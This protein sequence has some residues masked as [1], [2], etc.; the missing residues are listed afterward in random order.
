MGST[1][2]RAQHHKRKI[3]QCFIGRSQVWSRSLS[4]CK[5]EWIQ[6][7]RRWQARIF[8]MDNF[9]PAKTMREC[10]FYTW[11]MGTD[12]HQPAAIFYFHDDQCQRD[13][14]HTFMSFHVRLLTENR[15]MILPLI[16][17]FSSSSSASYSSSLASVF[18]IICFY[19]CQSLG[20]SFLIPS[21]SCYYSA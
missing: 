11:R 4:F 8:R 15:L 14:L 2:L 18:I 3:H 5:V 12:H 20:S 1:F 10:E 6:L 13:Y 7:S 9:S 19:V 21:P 16:C 17:H